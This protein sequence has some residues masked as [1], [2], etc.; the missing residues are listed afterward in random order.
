MF[1]V[2]GTAILAHMTMRHERYG[3]ISVMRVSGVRWMSVRSQPRDTSRGCVVFMV[4]HITVLIRRMR[5]LKVNVKYGFITFM[6]M[7]GVTINIRSAMRGRMERRS[8]NRPSI[9]VSMGRHIRIAS[10]SGMSHAML[11]AANYR[12]GRPG[13]SSVLMCHDSRVVR[14]CVFPPCDHGNGSINI[15]LMEFIGRMPMSPDDTEWAGAVALMLM[16]IV[17]ILGTTNGNGD[18]PQV[19]VIGTVW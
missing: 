14:V 9:F 15:M 3:L 19:A 2:E 1:M 11:A 12:H 17:V 8:C 13:S 4:A 16:I 10:I 5:M 6:R 18:G 7:G